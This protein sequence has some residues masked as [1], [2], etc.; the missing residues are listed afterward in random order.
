[1]KGSRRYEA[2]LVPGLNDLDRDHG[3]RLGLGWLRNNGF[4]GRPTIVLNAVK[5]IRNAPLLQQAAQ[6]FT[7]VSPRSSGVS[8]RGGPVLAVWPTE[9]TLTFA[10]DLALSFALCVIPGSIDDLSGWAAGRQPTVLGSTQT[11]TQAL[12]VPEDAEAAFRGIDNFDGHNDFLGAGG[13][14]YAIEHLRVLHGAGHLNP[15]DA[16]AWLRAHGECTADGAARIRKWAREI[17]AGK[18][19]RLD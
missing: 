18:R 9:S 17:L 7:V 15:E 5:M 3:L 2:F 4:S 12:T 10:E 1:M 6:E 11:A 16:F 13:K 14:R 8:R 19:H